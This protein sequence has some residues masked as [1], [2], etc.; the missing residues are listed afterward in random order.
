MN[1]NIAKQR[2]LEILNSKQPEYPPD[3]YFIRRNKKLHGRYV[4]KTE[5]DKLIEQ[6]PPKHRFNYRLFQLHDDE[7]DTK[8]FEK[9]KRN[10]KN[11]ND[12]YY[13]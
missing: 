3:I 8:R 4:D 7:K 9:V 6:V 1:K 10:L 5:M 11:K 2:A 13:R 12:P